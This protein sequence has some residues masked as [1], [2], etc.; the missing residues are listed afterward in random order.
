[1]DLVVAGLDA[2]AGDQQ[3]VA[4]LAAVVAG[5]RGEHA[6]DDHDVLFRRDGPNL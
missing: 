2:A 1:M 5:A 6:R 4:H 3:G